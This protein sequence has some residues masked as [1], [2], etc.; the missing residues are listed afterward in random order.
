MSQKYAIGI[1]YG[2]ESGRAVLVS[3]QDGREIADHVTPYRHG[4]MDEMLP[5]LGP[6]QNDLPS[7]ITGVIHGPGCA[8]LILC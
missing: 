6:N 2:T 5:S 7:S 8:V 3:L 1:D 4:V